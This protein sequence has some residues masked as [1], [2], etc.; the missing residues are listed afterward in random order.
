MTMF[1]AMHAGTGGLALKAETLDA[2]TW[3]H[4]T[5]PAMEAGG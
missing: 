5:L 4:Q 3:M 1:G 2:R